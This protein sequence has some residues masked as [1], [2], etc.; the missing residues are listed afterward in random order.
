MLL[1]ENV[2]DGLKWCRTETGCL[3]SPVLYSVYV[4][5]MLKDLEGKRLEI[6]VGGT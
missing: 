3:L 4:M 2:L 1:G 5:K 6:E